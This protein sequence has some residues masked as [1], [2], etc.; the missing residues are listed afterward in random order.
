L[1]QEVEN[2]IRHTYGNY[3]PGITP[4]SY[5]M[6]W[7]VSYFSRCRRELDPNQSLGMR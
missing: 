3:V 6:C 4:E 2:G 1:K 7:Y 5:R